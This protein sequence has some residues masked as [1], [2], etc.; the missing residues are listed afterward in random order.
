MNFYTHIRGQFYLCFIVIVMN[1]KLL[2][3][4]LLEEIHPDRTPHFEQFVIVCVV[5][6]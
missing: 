1:D 3:G 6:F 5:S 4:E 2:V